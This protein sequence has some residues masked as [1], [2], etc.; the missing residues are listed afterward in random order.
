MA[1]DKYG[2]TVIKKDFWADGG[3]YTAF[4]L[5]PL[6]AAWIIVFFLLTYGAYFTF[7]YDI[8]HAKAGFLFIVFAFLIGFD[9]IPFARSVW[10]LFTEKVIFTSERFMYHGFGSYS[11]PYKSI[12][13]M[14]LRERQ[15]P[16]GR[17]SFLAIIAADERGR[18]RAYIIPRWRTLSGGTLSQE[19]SKYITLT[20]LDRGLLAYYAY[21][22]GR[23]W[24]LAFI[25]AGTALSAILSFLVA[26]ASPE[27]TASLTVL[28]WLALALALVVFF[29][30]Y[31]GRKKYVTLE[32]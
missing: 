16:F 11:L 9:A 2:N 22:A 3:W 15:G 17:E 5:L 4:I 8:E 21:S 6:L 14:T 24:W 10:T 26:R 7:R 12:K 20:L 30:R 1:V 27:S 28:F 32:A 29:A 31:I 23:E 25:L 19:F 13:H 18:E